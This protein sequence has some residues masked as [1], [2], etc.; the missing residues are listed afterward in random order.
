ME[1]ATRKNGIVENGFKLIPEFGDEI[2]QAKYTACQM[3][4]FVRM[5]HP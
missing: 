2:V 1:Q 4:F 3:E 5:L